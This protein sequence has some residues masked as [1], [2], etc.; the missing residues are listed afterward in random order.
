M[1][2]R[3]FALSLALLVFPFASNAIAA[4][5]ITESKTEPSILSPVVHHHVLLS[6]P[7][8]GAEVT[9]DVAK[10]PAKSTGLHLI[11][12]PNGVD[13]EGA[14][15]RSNCIAGINGGYFD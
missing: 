6:D 8:S 1:R 4:W 12:N 15:S 9:L 14:M 5:T 7:S 13:L 2:C 10:F 11:D 3:Q